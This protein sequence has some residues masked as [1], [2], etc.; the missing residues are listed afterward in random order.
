MKQFIQIPKPIYAEQF[1]WGLETGVQNMDGVIYR[2]ANLYPESMGKESLIHIGYLA[3][4]DKFLNKKGF[5]DGEWKPFCQVTT[6]QRIYFNENSTHY[7]LR[8]DPKTDY[9]DGVIYKEDFE[10]DYTEYK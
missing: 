3:I 1:R 9:V 7:I 10:K 5:K 4:Y 6:G 2:N 8:Y